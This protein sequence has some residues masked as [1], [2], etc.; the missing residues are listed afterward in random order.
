MLTYLLATSVAHTEFVT[1]TRIEIRLVEIADRNE[2]LHEELEELIQCFIGVQRQ[3]T[4]TMTA[5]GRL[6]SRDED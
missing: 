5:L 3:A 6:M 2:H 4:S 1:R